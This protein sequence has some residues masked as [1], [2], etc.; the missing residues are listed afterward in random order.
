MIKPNNHE[1]N[2]NNNRLFGVEAA[3]PRHTSE[4]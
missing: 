1:S 3:G 4:W 2:N